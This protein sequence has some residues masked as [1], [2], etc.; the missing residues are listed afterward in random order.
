AWRLDVAPPRV[1]L[2]IEGDSVAGA[3]GRVMAPA[4]RLTTPAED[5]GSGVAGYALLLDG[6]EVD[7]FEELSTGLHRAEVVA[8]DRAGNRSPAAA[9]DFA[10]DAEPPVLEAALAWPAD[11][12]DGVVLRLAVTD[13]PAGLASL[14]WASPGGHW[15]ALGASAVAA[16]AP[17]LAMT[18][19]DAGARTAMRGEVR[20]PAE[21]AARGPLSLTALDRVGNEIRVELALPP[22]RG[23]GE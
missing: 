19:D 15:Q 7:D 13:Q 14:H 2:V 12:G 9:L 5:A 8:V 16:G 17:P 11:G 1:A 23:E 4:A 22:A 6:T 20:L 10:Y 18:F 3:H 21:A